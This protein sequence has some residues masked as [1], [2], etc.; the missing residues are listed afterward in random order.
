MRL[1]S[2]PSGHLQGSQQCNSD[3]AQWESKSG[4]KSASRSLRTDRGDYPVPI[5]RLS[6]D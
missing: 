1:G 6:V 4:V 3:V 5:G 2:E